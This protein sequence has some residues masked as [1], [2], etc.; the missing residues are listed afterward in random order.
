MV[1]AARAVAQKFA[2]VRV[3]LKINGWLDVAVTPNPC[4][5]TPATP[6]VAPLVVRVGPGRIPEWPLNLSTWETQGWD[7]TPLVIV[8]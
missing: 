2:T 8:S 6:L 1:V 3:T 5:G 4:K 7:A